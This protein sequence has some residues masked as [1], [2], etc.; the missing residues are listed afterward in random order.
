VKIKY[1]KRVEEEVEDWNDLMCKCDLYSLM[2]GLFFMWASEI[3]LWIMF[4][5]GHLIII[6]VIIF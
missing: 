2:N 4:H 3:T 5:P 6:I 1:R